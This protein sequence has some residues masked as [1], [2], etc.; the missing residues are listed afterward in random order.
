MKRVLAVIACMISFNAH[1]LDWQTEFLEAASQAIEEAASQAVETLRQSGVDINA[2]NDLG[3][4]ILYRVVAQ[5]YSSLAN[6]LIKQGADVNRALTDAVVWDNPDA[7][8]FLLQYE[9]DGNYIVNAEGY[10]RNYPL[11]LLANQKSFEYATL[12]LDKGA[13]INTVGGPTGET[14]LIQAIRQFDIAKAKTLLQ[15]GADIN[16]ASQQGFTPLYYAWLG[17]QMRDAE[18]GKRLFDFLLANK[19]D[20]NGVTPYVLENR[21]LDT[22]KVLIEHGAD[23]SYQLDN[24]KSLLMSAT[25]NAYNDIA[26][27]LIDNGADLDAQDSGGNTA[28]MLAIANDNQELARRLLERQADVNPINRFGNNALMMAANIGATDLVGR[29]LS[30]KPAINLRGQ[31]AATALSLAV[32]R[33][34]SETVG[35][36]LQANADPNL[37]IVDG[38][39]PLILAVQNKDIEGVKLL[40]EAGADSSIHDNTGKSA[41]DHAAESPEI[42]ELLST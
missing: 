15:R 28:L 6:E 18:A 2:P 30:N 34:H 22:L 26:R 41:L 9:I 13:D 10:G 21:D 39:T 29:I 3:Q 36:L 7:V 35:L 38:R 16:L 32:F 12:L 31:Y 27:Y 19:A 42:L 23:T 4:T 33:G 8:E 24:A 11:V 20:P 40:L 14:L 5:G 37:P 25:E 1:A 17:R